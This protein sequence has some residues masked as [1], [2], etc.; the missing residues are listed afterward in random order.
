[1]SA[2]PEQKECVHADRESREVHLGLTMV[3]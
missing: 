2:K 3:K 1:M